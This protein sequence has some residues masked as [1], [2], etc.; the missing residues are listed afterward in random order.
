MLLASYLF[1]LGLGAWL[2]GKLSDRLVRPARAYVAV[3]IGI[4]IYGILSGWLLERGAILYTLAHGWAGDSRGS[5]L[6]ARFLVSF[7]LVAL[8]TILMGGTFPLMVHLFKRSGVGVGRAAGRVYAVNTAGAAAA[9]IA[10]PTVLLP[11]LG[12]T[13]SLVVAAAWNLGAALAVHFET[14]DAAAGAE[15]RVDDESLAQ[16]SGAQ[17]TAAADPVEAG[18]NADGRAPSISGAALAGGSETPLG[19]VLIAFLLSSFSSIALES[20]WMRHFGIFF[21]AHIHTFAF[22]LVAYLVGLFLGG[23]LYARLVGR[24]FAPRLVL[25]WGLIV[26]V[27]SVGVTVPFLDR[28][29]IPQIEMMLAIG[30]S[31][32]TYLLTS[33]VETVLLILPPA[34]GFGLVFPAVVDLLAGGGRRPG[35]SAGLAYAVNTLGTTLGAVSAGFVLVPT[36]GSQRTIELSVLMLAAALALVSWPA[37]QGGLASGG[38]SLRATRGATAAALALP[39]AFLVL[40]LLPRWDPRM[41]HAMYSKDPLLF[42]R[43]YTGGAFDSFISGLRFPYVEEGTEATVSVCVFT[44]GRK[45]LFVNGKPDASD[46]PGDMVTQRLLG[47]VPGL[48][49]RNPERALVIGLGSGTTVGTLKRFPLERIDVAEISPEVAEAAR[50]HFSHVNEGFHDDPRVKLHLDDGRNFLRFQPPAS[51]DIIV[52]EPSNPWVSGVSALFTD[53]FFAEARSKLRPDGILCQWFHYYSMSIDHVRL[54]VRTFARQFPE[55]AM[56]ITRGGEPTGDMI[57]IGANGKLRMWRLPEDPALPPPVRAA[58]TEAQNQGAQQL[59]SGLAGGPNELARFAGSGPI[60]TDDRPI[61]EFEAPADRFVTVFSENLGEL[62]SAS[63]RTFLPAGPEPEAADSTSAIHADGF[64]LPRG[65]P[66]GSET[67]RGA[68]VLTRVR[69]GGEDISRWVLLGREFERRGGSATALYRLARLPGPGEVADI[70]GSLAGA[71][72]VKSRGETSVGGHPAAWVLSESPSGRTVAVGWFC[73][74][75]N[76]AL[77]SMLRVPPSDLLAAEASAAELASRFPCSHEPR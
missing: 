57:L 62:L 42:L 35:A 11:S 38:R 72:G 55:S 19:L 63:E 32:T 4:G 2:V 36:I 7:V 1:G 70:A 51:Y 20:V 66:E 48:F 53:E 3:E 28:L 24:G 49:H 31:H 29:S 8:P 43:R 12:V 23:A 44:D 40:P 56:L 14:R 50:L 34:L 27:T 39:A 17:P 76:R 60:N 16:V 52:S 37:G 21:G 77:F 5:L 54:L 68:L 33:A 45:S 65:L 71:R 10:L 59:L 18:R 58:L 15:G 73:A 9:A 74:E 22:V 6:L 47:A 41:A 67:R 26:S 75:R 46:I 25:R 69:E 64:G 61:L 13:L 30:V